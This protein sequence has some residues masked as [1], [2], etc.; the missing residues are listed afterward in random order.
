M[1][2]ETTHRIKCD[3]CPKGMQSTVQ[4]SVAEIRKL[5]KLDG[6]KRHRGSDPNSE[7]TLKWYDICP[8]CQIRLVDYLS[9]GE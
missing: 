2:V 5:A 6:W 3:L 1:S 4:S 9:E 7:D 8:G